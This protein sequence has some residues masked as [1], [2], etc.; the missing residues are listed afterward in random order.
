MSER[1]C[2]MKVATDRIRRMGEGNVF[3]LSTGGGGGGGGTPRYLPS[4]KV[5]DPPC[6]GQDG[7]KR[8]PKVP[9]TP[10]AKVPTPP[11]DRTA[12]GVLDTPRSVCL[13][14]S[15]RRTFLFMMGS[16]KIQL[17]VMLSSTKYHKIFV[18]A[19]AFTHHKCTLIVIHVEKIL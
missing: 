6:P 9:T 17:A 12:Y 19:F 1:E 16:H 11:R 7:G 4:T 14:R 18:F 5:P 3:N 8:Y 13:L 10:L 15:R 2:K